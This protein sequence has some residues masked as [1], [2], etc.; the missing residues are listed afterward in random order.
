M[1]RLAALLCCSQTQPKSLHFASFTTQTH[2]RWSE[3]SLTH[4]HQPCWCFQTAPGGRTLR[5]RAGS[6]PQVHKADNNKAFIQPPHFKAISSPS[7]VR[8]RAPHLCLLWHFLYLLLNR[9]SSSNRTSIMPLIPS[10]CT[11]GHNHLAEQPQFGV[12]THYSPASAMHSGCTLPPV[13]LRHAKLKF[14]FIQLSIL[15]TIVACFN[16]LS[17]TMDMT[18]F[19]GP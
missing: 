19:L 7:A 13:E 15:I 10:L 6:L 1:L 12:F 5:G 16:I 11:H 17:W 9:Y 18:Y 14:F 4:S 8:G 3:S 2:S